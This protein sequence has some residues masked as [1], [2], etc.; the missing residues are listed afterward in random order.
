[1][2]DNRK[3]LF[4]FGFGFSAQELARN[5][6]PLGWEIAGTCREGE[7]LNELSQ[8]GWNGIIFDTHSSNSNLPEIF[9]KSSHLLISIPPKLSDLVLDNYRTDIMKKD[10]LEWIGY[11]ST[12]GVYGNKNGELVDE[13]SN[14][15]P[16]MDRAKRRLEAE[17]RW[18]ELFKEYK[19]P[20]HIFRCVGIYGPGRNPLHTVRNGLG[21]R[22]EKPGYKFS[23]IHVED[24]ASVLTASIN[25]P[26]PGSIYNVCDD[27]PIESRYV[28]EYACELLKVDL[29]PLVPFEEA[30]LSDMAKSFYLDRKTI[31][32]KKIKDELEVKLKFPNYKIGLNSLLGEEGE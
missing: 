2:N 22:I 3:K 5:L 28:T 8:K 7:K 31:S 23:R 26:N 30:N 13:N 17:Y 29:P 4:C 11:L 6:S 12:T 9:W 24:L 20:V 25:K 10:N 21:K 32:N 16:T 1:M 15:N 27:L 18:L 14:L 19:L